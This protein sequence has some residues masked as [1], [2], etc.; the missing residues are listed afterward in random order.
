MAVD[1]S[2]KKFRSTFDA[3]KTRIL[4]AIRDC[5]ALDNDLTTMLTDMRAGM[6]RIRGSASLVIRIT[7][8]VVSN[9]NH[10]LSLIKELRG[11]KKD[12]I[13]REI[14]LAEKEADLTAL[15]AVGSVNA[16]LLAQLQS[17]ILVPGSTAALLEPTAFTTGPAAEEEVVAD[18]DTG[19]SFELPDELRIGDI[20][21]DPEGNLYVIT[22]DGAED[23]GMLAAELHPDDERP[24]AVL[25]DGRAVLI[26]DIAAEE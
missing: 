19:V 18:G 3:E 26:V 20:V 4:A 2:D 8:Q 17:I 5:E 23:A 24:Y 1:F 11:L 6:N 25:A 16:Q 15:T 12:V 10:R 14:R 13:D 9:R 21:A 22:E 7:E